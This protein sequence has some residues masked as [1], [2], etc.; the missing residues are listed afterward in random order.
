MLEGLGVS[1]I[2]LA[3]TASNWCIRASAY[4]ALDRGIDLTLIGDAHTT[5][6]ME[7]GPG[8]VVEARSVIDDL[9]S[10]MQWL[11]YPGRKDVVVTAADVDFNSAA[12][13]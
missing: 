7:L 11:S 8:R 3:G 2:L 12:A 9:N 1:H 4:G 10:T 5:R 6:D 13:V